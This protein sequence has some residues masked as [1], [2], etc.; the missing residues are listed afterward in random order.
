MSAGR[1]ELPPAIAAERL[2]VVSRGPSPDD[3]EAATPVLGAHGFHVLE[4]TLDSESPLEGIERLRWKDGLT[5]GAGTVSSARQAREAIQAGATFV[6]TPTL[7]QEV[8]EE[9]VGRGIACIPGTF[10]PTE[11]QLAWR[12]GAAAVKIFPAGSLGP[13]YLAALQGPLSD[14]PLIPSGGI[15]GD[16]VP[17]YLS[18][19]AVAVG[20]GGW[21]PLRNLDRLDARA[22]TVSTALATW[23]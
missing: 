12:L 22:R 18:A 4:V 3:L 9:C 10:S 7:N 20:V 8:I 14:V 21:L 17:A 16:D 23:C 1:P 13:G 5:V 2:I 11:V 15:T 6:V 19:G